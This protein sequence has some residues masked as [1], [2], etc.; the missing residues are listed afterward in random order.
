MT[1]H[2]TSFA[3]SE[4]ICSALP[5]LN[6]FNVFVTTLEGLVEI[7]TLGVDDVWD[8]AL[9]AWIETAEAMRAEVMKRAEEVVLLSEG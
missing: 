9:D 6:A 8:A 7:E 5:V 1:N 2:Q 3:A 4:Q